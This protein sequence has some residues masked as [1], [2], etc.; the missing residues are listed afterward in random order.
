MRGRVWSLPKLG[1]DVGVSSL[2]LQVRACAPC[3]DSEACLR[4]FSGARIAVVFC[5]L[6][7]FFPLPSSGFRREGG[8]HL[9]SELEGLWRTTASPHPLC[10]QM[11]KQT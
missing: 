6:I 1:E 11:R 9:W 2:Y 3:N 7:H 8:A 5:S 10:L 4:P